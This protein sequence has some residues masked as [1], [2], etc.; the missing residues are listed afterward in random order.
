MCG[1]FDD[2]GI[3][4]CVTFCAQFYACSLSSDMGEGC[5]LP[6]CC[7]I[8]AMTNLRVKLRTQ[9]NIE[10]SIACDNCAMNCCF[11]CAL[12]QLGREWQI[13]QKRCHAQVTTTQII[14][15]HA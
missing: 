4:L 11:P 12:C 3:C 10:G 14:S 7:G 2:C 15:R 8:G 1:C 5:C 9:E 6:V 13:V